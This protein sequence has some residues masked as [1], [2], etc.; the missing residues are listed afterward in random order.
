M[1]TSTQ[2]V[3]EESDSRITLPPRYLF[4][5]RAPFDHAIEARLAPGITVLDIGSGRNPAVALSSRPDDVTYIGLDVSS[6][7]L[8]AAEPGSYDEHVVVDAARLYE[9]LRGRADLAVSW[10]VLEHVRDLRATIDNI[11]A[12]LKPGGV[13]IS[14]FSG[15]FSAFGVINQL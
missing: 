11:G 6:D 10:Q 14:L 8:S 13:F 12:Y 9:P 4:D 3:V 2:A 15:S 7:E 5:W 1:S